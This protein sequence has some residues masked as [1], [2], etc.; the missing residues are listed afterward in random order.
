MM[1]T[2]TKPTIEILVF[3]ADENI[4]SAPEFNY[5]DGV[6]PGSVF[7]LGASSWNSGTPGS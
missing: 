1:R 3:R 7:D 2:Y 5:T 6:I 4:A